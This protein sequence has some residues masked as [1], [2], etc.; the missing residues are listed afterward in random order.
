M[1]IKLW[2]VQSWFKLLLLASP[3]LINDQEKQQILT[4]QKQKPENILHF[5]LKNDLNNEWIRK[6]VTFKL[7][8]KKRQKQN[9]TL[10]Y[11]IFV[12]LS[13][14]SIIPL[15]HYCGTSLHM[16]KTQVRQIYSI[17][18]LQAEHIYTHWLQLGCEKELGHPGGLKLR[19]WLVVLCSFSVKPNWTCALRL[20]SG[21]LHL[22]PL[23]NEVCFSL[24]GTDYRHWICIIRSS[25]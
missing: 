1:S 17:L 2:K 20:W 9:V 5:C 3:M 16:D 6:I 21:P 18:A 8:K 15:I 4:I 7:F 14:L 22:H 25:A 19:E 13:P 24:P 10:R 11:K 12:E 23:C